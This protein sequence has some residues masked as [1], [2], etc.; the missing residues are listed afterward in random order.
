M[1]GRRVGGPKCDCSVLVTDVE[2]GVVWILA[3]GC[4]RALSGGMLGD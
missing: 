3:H 4:W 2:D 1:G